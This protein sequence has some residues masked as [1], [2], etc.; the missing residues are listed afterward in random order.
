MDKCGGRKNTHVRARI[1]IYNL[2]DNLID[3]VSIILTLNSIHGNLQ[4]NHQFCDVWTIF[5]FQTLSA[6]IK[7]SN[8]S[9]GFKSFH[10][11]NS[12]PIRPQISRGHGVWKLNTC[13]FKGN[14]YFCVIKEVIDKTRHDRV[15]NVSKIVW[16]MIKCNVRV[17]TNKYAC[18]RGE[19]QTVLLVILQSKLKILT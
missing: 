14:E 8:I 1:S 16:D 3:S 7:Y 18:K 12:I 15:R 19:I 2:M 9:H 10:S 13:L 5:G 6:R 17:C 4:L 11:L